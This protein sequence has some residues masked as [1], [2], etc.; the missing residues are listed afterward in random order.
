MKSQS[1]FEAFVS[2][3]AAAIWNRL[4]EKPH[5]QA[6]KPTD[7]P[8]IYDEIARALRPFWH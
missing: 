6:L 7:F 3:V 8:E 1:E 2:D 4:L 5:F